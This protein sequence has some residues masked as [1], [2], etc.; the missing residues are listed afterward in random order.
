M[1]VW[2]FILIG[3]ESRRGCCVILYGMRVYACVCMCAYVCVYG[4]VC[5]YVCVCVACVGVC[6]RARRGGG[7]G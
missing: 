2:V 4:C 5:V 1:R 3:M 7:K 6:V